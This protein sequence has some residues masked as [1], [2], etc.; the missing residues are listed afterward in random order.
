MDWRY[1]KTLQVHYELD[2]Y[3][4][5]IIFTL[6]RDAI[7]GQVKGGGNGRESGEKTWGTFNQ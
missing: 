1:V 6:T 2:K 4:K 5:T 7:V 3:G